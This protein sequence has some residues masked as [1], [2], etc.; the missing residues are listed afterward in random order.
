MQYLE[1]PCL[2]NPLFAFIAEENFAFRNTAMAIKILVLKGTH[3][4]HSWSCPCV[5]QVTS[6]R[7]VQKRKCRKLNKN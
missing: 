5:I 7:L 4:L 6:E 2:S 1:S 3:N